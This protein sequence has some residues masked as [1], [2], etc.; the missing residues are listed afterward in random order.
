M[1]KEERKYDKVVNYTILKTVTC[2][3]GDRD[4]IYIL[5][6]KIFVDEGDE[7]SECK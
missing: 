5:F 1:F 7:S 6:F 3:I 2:L 4:N